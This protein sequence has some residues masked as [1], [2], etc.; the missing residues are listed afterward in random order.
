MTTVTWAPNNA[1]LG[2]S[3]AILN[4]GYAAG[5]GA[6]CIGGLML[7]PFALKYGRR[8]IYLFSTAV[9]CGMA[10]W[11]ARMENV[12][13]L[14]LTNV[15]MCLVGALAEVL[16]QMTVADVYFVHQ[17]GLMNSIYVWMMTFGSNLAPLAGGYVVDAQGWRWVWWWMAIWIGVGLVAFVFLY[18]ETKFTPAETIDGLEPPQVMTADANRKQPPVEDVKAAGAA[19]SSDLEKDTEKDAAMIAATPGCTHWIDYSIPKRTYGQMLVP[20]TNSPSSLLHLA[21]HAYQP[22]LLLASIPA[23]FYVA[24]VYGAMTASSTVTVTTLSS[25]MAEAPY[26]FGPSGIGLMGLP[27]FIG[28]SLGTMVCGPLSDRLVL[29]L[30]K[31]NKGVFE[32]EVRLWVAVGFIIFVPAGLFM[33]G[34][35]LNNGAHWAVPAVGL[36]IMSFG[37]V[38]LG[39]IAL[40][41]LTDAYTDVSV[42]LELTSN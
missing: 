35:G 8:P 21:R 24:L 3:Y 31:R 41:Y 19:S 42:P 16:V 14:M 1:Q 7:I 10:I 39:G 20:W 6:L 27:P 17:R 32:P 37:S 29:Y 15:L 11:S 33:F 12:P 34:I 36:G 40:T 25:Y 26:N 9:Q 18:E 4:D 5:C 30:S 2:F 22:F 23:V 38:P 13:D 28:T